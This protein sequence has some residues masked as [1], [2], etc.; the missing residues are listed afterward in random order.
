MGEAE[1]LYFLCLL[2]ELRQEQAFNLW[3]ARCANCLEEA[4]VELNQD[5]RYGRIVGVILAFG[6][7]KQ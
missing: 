1:R 4:T 3:D 7:N 5:G 2:D 6:A